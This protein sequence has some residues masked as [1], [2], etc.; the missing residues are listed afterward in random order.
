[1]ERAVNRQVGAA[2]RRMRENAALCLPGG[3]TARIVT[4]ALIAMHEQ[5]GLTQTAGRD[6]TEGIAVEVRRRRTAAIAMAELDRRGS[7]QRV[8]KHTHTP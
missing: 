3:G 2:T 1:M 4:R 7:P 5:D 6:R 8:A